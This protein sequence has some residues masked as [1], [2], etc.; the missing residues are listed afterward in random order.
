MVGKDR[1]G[2]ATCRREQPRCREPCCSCALAARLSGD[3]GCP[4]G[5]EISALDL[6]SQV[7]ASNDFLRK[8]TAPYL[9]ETPV[10]TLIG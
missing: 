4:V 10:V 9:S 3:E 7:P 8:R 6:L 5:P 1:M 2:D